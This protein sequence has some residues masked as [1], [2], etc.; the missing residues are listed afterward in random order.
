MTTFEV[1]FTIPSVAGW[2]LQKTYSGH[3][4]W[5]YRGRIVQ[6][7]G[8]IVAIAILSISLGQVT[9][10]YLYPCLKTDKQCYPLLINITLYNSVKYLNKTHYIAQLS[11]YLPKLIMC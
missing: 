2:E 7:S 8:R 3:I 10:F 1:T 5:Q 4:L 6:S 9:L 11:C